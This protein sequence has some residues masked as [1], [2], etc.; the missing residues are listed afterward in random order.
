MND[1]NPLALV[2]LLIDAGVP[3]VVIGGHAV[4]FY[5]YLRA[6][7]DVDVL[8][9]RTPA[10]ERALAEV[11]RAADAFRISNEIDPSTGIEKTVPVTLDYIRQNH[12]MML[13]SKYGYIDL[14]DFVPGLPDQGLGDVLA[15]ATV[16]GNRPFVSLD[17]LKRMKR[18]SDRPQD[19]IDLDHLP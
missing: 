8:F 3:L 6:T 14:F 18:A 12:L 2:D 17:W 9:Q 1:S 11:L 16:A 5:G 4:N 7:E 15:T 19:R 10:S 13:G